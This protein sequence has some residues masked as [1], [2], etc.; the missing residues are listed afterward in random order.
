[1][2]HFQEHNPRV[3]TV[4]WFGEATRLVVDVTFME[5]DSSPPHQL[6]HMYMETVSIYIAVA[7]VAALIIYAVERFTTL[8]A[9]AK[10]VIVWLIVTAV[11][12]LLIWR[13]WVA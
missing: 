3:G 2:V 7:L 5:F 10:Q 9:P 4:T 6:I 1:M 11:V 8:S 13:I 12:L